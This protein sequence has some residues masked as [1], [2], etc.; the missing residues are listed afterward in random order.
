MTKEDYERLKSVALKK[1]ELSPVSLPKNIY[2][3]SVEELVQINE[4]YQAELEAQNDELQT[5]VFNLEEAQ[6]E[7]EVLFTHAPIPYLL[8][9]SKFN[10]IRANKEALEMFN[11]Q[12]FLSKN[13]PFYTHLEKGNTT[14][15]LDW[16]HNK[17]REHIPLETPLH[18][19]MGLR[20]C[21]LHYH[22]WSIQESD[23]FLLSIID[24]H[25]QKEENDRFKALFENRQQ[26]V[27]YL[28]VNNVIVSLNETALS[29]IGKTKEECISMFYGDLNWTFMGR[30]N[31]R[32][33]LDELPFAKT[34]QTKESCP[35]TVVSVY[36]PSTE[37]RLWLRMETMPHFSLKNKELIGVFC[38][39]TDV[40]KEYILDKELNQQLDNFKT[41]AN[42]LPDVLL[43]I[44][45]QQNIL[46]MNKHGCDF[47]NIT[48]DE[49]EHLKLCDFSIFITQQADNVCS[50]LND[51]GKLSSPI[52][53]SLNQKTNESHKNYFLRIIPEKT[54]NSKKVFLIVLEDITER[55]ESEDMFNQL[56]Y[57]ASDA[58]VLTDHKTGE[59]KSINA[60]AGKLL[61]FDMTKLQ[62]YTSRDILE[63][64]KSKDLYH[65]HIETLETF[66]QDSYEA[67]RTLQDKSIQYLKIFCTLIDIGHETYHQ[68]IIHDLTEHKLLEMQLQQ[69]SR[70]F[71]HTTEGILITKL[72]GTIISANDAF[73][74]ITGYSSREV[75]GKNPAL[76]QS[77]RHDKEFY[78]AMWKEIANNGLWKGEIWNKKKDGTVYPEWLAISTIYDD[79]GKATQYVAVFSDFSEIKK[80][81][82]KLENLAHYDQLTKLPNRLL[83]NEQIKQS[84]KTAK[85]NKNQFAV[86]FID[87][88]RFKQINDTYGHDIGD[89]VLKKTAKRLKSVL[90]ETDIVARLG[91]DEFIVVV[92]EMKYIE[93][94][95]IVAQSILHKLQL[96]FNIDA[97]EHYIS[98]SIGISIYPDDNVDGDVLLKNAD[99]AMY[100]SKAAGKNNY[101]MFSKSMEERVKALSSLHN[102]LNIALSNDEFY[103]VYQPQYDVYKEKLLGF[104]ALLRWKHK[105]KG[106]IG[107]A[108]FI[109]YTEESKLIIPIGKW[110]IKKAIE[111]Y[112]EM[113][114][115][116]NKD[117]TISVNVS[118]VQLSV[119][120]INTLKELMKV[121]DNLEKIIKIEI[122]ETSAMNNLE[123]TQFIIGEIKALGFKI[124]LDDF[125]TG[126]SALNAIKTL[127]VDEIKID[128]SFIKDVPGDKDDEELVSTII[129]M[130][131]VMKKSVVAEGVEE[132]KTKDF[133]LERSCPIIQGYFISKP[134]TLDKA[135]QYLQKTNH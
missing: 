11:S 116:L 20:F 59:I 17:D 52:T 74:K 31:K 61:D 40:S 4:I 96:P 32:L 50:I 130:A 73:L 120:L 72:N 34:M 36:I 113:K 7:L 56:F 60:K 51:L 23:T 93:N 28:D 122:T 16:I 90:R 53:Y 47:F 89:E 102:D 86:L 105:T 14:T 57:N 111:G 82:N 54:D 25:A 88:D 8:M 87:L 131:K 108:A 10:I 22:K 127:R 75:I 35:P 44:D 29:L 124:S 3:K 134:L 26:G 67:T 21:A 24:I 106:E 66:G 92:N 49:V 38:I 79:D 39:F 112:E 12:T 125:G 13:T 5:N 123:N 37:T 42:N 27:V 98:C 77:G 48:I 121:H 85:R 80:N 45:E 43:R 78:K 71:E 91:G 1:L 132:E 95:H 109:P 107:P 58:I 104:E 69:N 18:T 133:L 83:L 129:A 135:I 65:K 55:V 97:N 70:V 19:S 6:N 68:S 100:E 119:D 9:T 2:G 62:E 81:Q 99:I 101:H 103:L 117:I 118:H 110:V 41:L 114:K 94:V 15:F 64:F 33:S 63:S 115:V 84:V 128:R 30:D 76:L 46:F 126:Y